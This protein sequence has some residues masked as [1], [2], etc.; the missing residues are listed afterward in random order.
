MRMIEFLTRQTPEYSDT[1]YLDG[2]SPSQILAAA[3]KSMLQD[4]VGESQEE[5][6][7]VI[8]SETEV[9]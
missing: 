8:S 3:H 1:L 7:V 5:T 6:V 9:E 2:Y 4:L